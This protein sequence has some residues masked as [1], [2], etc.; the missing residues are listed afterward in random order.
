MRSRTWTVFI[1]VNVIVSAAVMLTIL[2]VWGR[3]HAPASPTST[4]SSP[5]P[6]P[7]PTLVV[8][9]E[10]V[11]T[12]TAPPV[13]SPTPPGPLLYTVQ[14]GD[15]LGVIA[16]TY[17]VSV[18]DLMAANGLTDANVLRVGQTLVVPIDGLPTPTPG[19]TAETRLESSPTVM[20]LPTL[21]PTPTPS[22]P[23]LVEIG[24]VLGSGDVAAEVVVVR[25]R[26]GAVNLEGWTLSDAEE[27][28]FVFPAITL[29]NDVEVRVHSTVGTFVPSDLYWGRTTSAWSG[30]ELITL[31]DAAGSV[32]DTYIVP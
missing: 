24:Q 9:E 12:P 19:P 10:A 20:P 29:F 17:G 31:R 27:N 22:G 14:E 5:A 6:T 28:I 23:P 13:A 8:A 1:V 11:S 3:V 30:G 4:P 15:T 32:V 16:Q 18:E 2:F 26:G 7:T 21:L 25:N